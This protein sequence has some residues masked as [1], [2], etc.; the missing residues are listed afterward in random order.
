MKEMLAFKE[1]FIYAIFPTPTFLS[2]ILSFCLSFISHNKIFFVVYLKFIICSA[3]K[4][5]G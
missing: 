4:K 2:L 1:V 5:K 3:F